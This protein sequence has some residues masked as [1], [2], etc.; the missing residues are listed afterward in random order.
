MGLGRRDPDW[1][2]TVNPLARFDCLKCE[3]NLAGYQMVTRTFCVACAELVPAAAAERDADFR[4]LSREYLT[5]SIARLPLCEL[6][7]VRT[8]EFLATRKAS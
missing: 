2:R 4:F 3:Q 5:R 8:A 6:V 7:D 1:G